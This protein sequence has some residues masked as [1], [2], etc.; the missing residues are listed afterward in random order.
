VTQVEL[1]ASSLNS[2]DVFILD[3]GMKIWQVRFSVAHRSR[4]RLLCHV[5]QWNGRQSSPNEKAKAGQ[6]CRAMKSERGGKP[7]L[8]NIG[9]VTRYIRTYST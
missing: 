5:R 2:G 8:I 3:T 4:L 6:I 7:E 9:T 1:S